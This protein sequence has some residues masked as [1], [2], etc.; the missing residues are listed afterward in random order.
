MELKV[1]IAQSDPYP[2]CII[3]DSEGLYFRRNNQE[4]DG[5]SCALYAYSEDTE[6]QEGDLIMVDHKNFNGIKKV[7][8]VQGR[9]LTEDDFVVPLGKLNLVYKIEASSN[10]LEDNVRLIPGDFVREFVLNHKEI[11]ENGREFRI[12]RKDLL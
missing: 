8:D 9:I 7:K 3:Q 11:I 2:N 10:P 5:N 1:L 6:I 4:I 12:T